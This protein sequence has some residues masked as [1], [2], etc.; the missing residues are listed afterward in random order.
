MADSKWDQAIERLK[1]LNV[2]D[3]II[4]QLEDSSDL[5]KQLKDLAPKAAK[6]E[7]L[8]KK[9]AKYERLPK[10]REAFQKKGV[11]LEELRPA[12]LRALEAFEFE[13]DEIPDDKVVEF[14][15]EYDLPLDAE[16]QLG[17]EEGE[18]PP[19]ERITTE[20]LRNRTGSSP[21]RITPEMTEDWSTDDL[22]K[23]KQK[24]PE[25]YESLKQGEPV[26]V[27]FSPKG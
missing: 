2:P 19:A 24:H 11:V 3:D 5:R 7:D 16:G 17:V 18:R 15:K 9:L 14:I 21:T 12:E 4:E 13:G 20:A 1:E 10:V 6:A 25:E 27:V 22:M 23:F 8:E 26:S